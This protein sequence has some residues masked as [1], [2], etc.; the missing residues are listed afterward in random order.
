MSTTL[1]A[2]NF[3][4]L[5]ISAC[6]LPFTF[7]ASKGPSLPLMLHLCDPCLTH[8]AFTGDWQIKG[9]IGVTYATDMGY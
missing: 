8:T 9:H 1:P 3:R 6:G 2:C 4:L 7:T 5:G